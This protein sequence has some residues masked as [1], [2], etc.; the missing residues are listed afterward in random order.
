VSELEAEVSTLLGRPAAVF[1][2]SGTMAQQ[3]A[4]RIHADRR[5]RRTVV[6]HPACHVDQNE[7][8]GYERLH[9]LM[10]RPAGDVNRLLTLEDLESVAEA[11]AAL[12]LELPQR[13]LGGQLPAWDDLVAQTGW[14]RN[15]G[16]AVHL[17]G[18]RL[19]ECT[20][21]Y[22]RSLSDIAE[23]FDTVYVSF[24][25]GLGGL[26]GCCLAGP[27][28]VIAEAREWRTRHGGTLFALWPYAASGLAGLRARL[29]RIDR[30][31]E[32]ARA[33]AAALEKVDGVEVVPAHVQAPM[34]HLLF[35]SPA[36]S[37]EAAA[38]RLAQ[39]EGL[40][41]WP[42]FQS[43]SAPDIQRAELVVGDGTLDFTPEE[44]RRVIE[45][46]LAG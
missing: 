10:G 8:R 42:R 40:W 32:H 6:F 5:G 23:L 37:L 1:M 41:T 27:D 15:R 26:T 34:M 21:F 13:D 28:D 4:L 11:P 38:R 44:C 39:D 22:E 29:P 30:Y 3:I 24:Y 20:P 43:T 14:A 25:K 45:E 2:P 19:W 18:A 33:C 17:D 35:R 16:A 46:L 36:A 9:G 31:F 12:L 7:E